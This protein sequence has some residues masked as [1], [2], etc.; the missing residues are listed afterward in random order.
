MPMA[1]AAKASRWPIR[2]SL[3]REK[4]NCPADLSSIKA[5]GC[6]AI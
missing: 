4:S 5:F 3:S 2:S 6:F 1:A